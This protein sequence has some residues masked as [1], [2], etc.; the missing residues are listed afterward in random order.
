MDVLR[1]ENQN[2]LNSLNE[3][4]EE[5]ITKGNNYAYVLL[6]AMLAA[7]VISG[8]TA[9]NFVHPTVAKK[10]IPLMKAWTNAVLT[11]IGNRWRLS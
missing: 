10:I 4:W 6:T 8:N 7:G 5:V 11:P 1:K 3:E 2:F 9:Y